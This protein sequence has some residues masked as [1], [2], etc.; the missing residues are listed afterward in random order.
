MEK[1]QILQEKKLDTEKK[2]ESMI[3]DIG[4]DTEI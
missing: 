1:K 3:I 4:S 2:E